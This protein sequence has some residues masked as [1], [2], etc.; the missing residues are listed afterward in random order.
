MS[1]KKYY[2]DEI[3]IPGIE[4]SDDWKEYA[5]LEREEKVTAEDARRLLHEVYQAKN[6][7]VLVP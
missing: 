7:G 3:V 6:D 2:L 1:E 5:R 4:P